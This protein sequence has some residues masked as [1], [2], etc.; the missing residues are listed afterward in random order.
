MRYIRCEYD[1]GY[2]GEEEV[3]FIRFPNKTTDLEIDEYF[4]EW[5]SDYISDTIGVVGTREDFD[6]DE[7]YE[8]LIESY[9]E[10]VSY[11]WK[12]VNPDDEEYQGIFW[13]DN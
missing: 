3:Y 12:Q 4:K 2:I 7:E 13:E 5:L 8:S 11:D 6:S 1:C 10:C 9:Y